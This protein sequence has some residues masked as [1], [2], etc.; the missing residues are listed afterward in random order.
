MGF[1]QFLR[2]EWVIA[3]AV[4]AIFIVFVPSRLYAQQQAGPAVPETRNPQTNS[5]QLFKQQ[6]E[7]QPTSP[8]QLLNQ[9]VK[10][11]IPKGTPIRSRN[12]VADTSKSRDKQLFL[13]ALSVLAVVSSV[14]LMKYAQKPSDNLGLKGPVYSDVKIAPTVPGASILVKKHK[15]PRKKKSKGKPRKKH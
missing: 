10:I 13:L 9:S 2:K 8:Q 5:P 15:H 6:T 7:V 14:I 11:E 4:L 3:A 12:T 1:A